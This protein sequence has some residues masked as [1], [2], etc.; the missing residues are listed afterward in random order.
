MKPCGTIPTHQISKITFI[1][2]FMFLLFNSIAFAEAAEP[3]SGNDKKVISEEFRA[4]GVGVSYSLTN[5]FLDRSES[6]PSQEKSISVQGVNL[7]LTSRISEYV[8]YEADVYLGYGSKLTVGST[9]DIQID[10]DLSEL[11]DMENLTNYGM[12]GM[13]LVGR[14]I[15]SPGF[16]LVAGAGVYV[17]QVVI[18]RVQDFTLTEFVSGVSGKFEIGYGWEQVGT[19][20]WVAIRT[21][22]VTGFEEGSAQGGLKMSYLFK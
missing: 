19:T 5:Y 1:S 2:V 20:F 9:D 21:G 16:R 12:Q 22:T 6:D 14:K 17:E 15:A 13:L 18:Q 3:K 10:Y 4:N 11:T 8:G 7:S